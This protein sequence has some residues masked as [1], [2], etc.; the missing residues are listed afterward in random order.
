VTD[1]PILVTGA[2]GLLGSRLRRTAPVGCRVVSVLHRDR[3]VDGPAVVADLR[4][5]AATADAVR[6]VRPALVLHAAYAKDEAAIVAATRNVVDAAEAVGAAVLLV[7]TDAVYSGDGR[8]RREDDPPDPI[9][10]YGRWKAQAEE[11]VLAGVPGSA[12]VR[13]PLV[14]SVDPDDHVVGR[15][16]AAA[17]RAEC[18]VW[19][20]DELRQPA[21]AAELAEAVWRIASLDARARAGIWH[22]PG[23]ELLSR[24]EIAR[25]VA[26]ALGLAD[27]AVTAEATP[28]GLDRP[29]C[30]VLG[31]RRAR[32][33][34]G[35]SPTPILR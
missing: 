28:P 30:L 3:R 27:D 18:T 1:G 15:I 9:S 22:L 29:R 13:L 34:I 4:D 16:R 24:H 32:A 6:E 5:P 8:P 2:S 21:A 31:D 17:D 33:E 20:D 35:W 10:D 12:I 7:S 26:A 11:L 14:V 19:F 23:P 25:R